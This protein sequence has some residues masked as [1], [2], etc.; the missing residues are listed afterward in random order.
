MT[1][2]G[3]ELGIRAKRDAIIRAAQIADKNSVEYFLV[4]ETHP[5]FFGVNALD[6][7]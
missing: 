7:L 1:E 2:I 4:P 6:V 3:I 5:E